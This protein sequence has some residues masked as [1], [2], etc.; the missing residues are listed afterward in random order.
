[1]EFTPQ[2]TY[3]Y[4][5]DKPLNYVVHRNL[6]ISNKLSGPKGGPS[7]VCLADQ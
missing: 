4:G 5:Y 1:V 6:P 3:Y 2:E 7:L